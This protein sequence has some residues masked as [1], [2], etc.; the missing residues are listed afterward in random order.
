MTVPRSRI[1]ERFF[2]GAAYTLV[3][4]GLAAGALLLFLLLSEADANP[5]TEQFK[6]LK[7][8]PGPASMALLGTG[9]IS[10]HL[11]LRCR[12]PLTDCRTHR[13]GNRHPASTYPNLRG[14]KDE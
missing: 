2:A 1:R 7:I 10:A 13:I 3:A 8:L 14:G 6:D 5:A 12:R 9:L 11:V 4:F